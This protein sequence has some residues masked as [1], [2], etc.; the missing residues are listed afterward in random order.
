MKKILIT[1]LMFV[2]VCSSYAQKVTYGSFDVLANEREVCVKLDYTG[3]MIDDLPFDVFLETEDNWD[4]GN[5]EI[6]LK[7]IKEANKE[8]SGILFLTKKETK[9]ILVFKAISVSGRGT[10]IG[11]LNLLDNED[12]IIAKT[13]NFKAR[14]G[15]FGTHI[16]LMGDAAERLG[17][18]VGSFI[19]EQINK[20]K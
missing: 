2:C 6:L 4:K 11:Y 12:N 8:E 18:M 19:K 9:Y 16:N 15:R 3:A 17:E 14:G 13:D 5:R 7:F 20:R 10:T 1:A